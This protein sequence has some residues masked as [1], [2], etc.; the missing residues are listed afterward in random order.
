MRSWL[1]LA[2]FALQLTASPEC[3]RPS[4]ISGLLVEAGP[5]PL[6]PYR[7]CPLAVTNHRISGAFLDREAFLW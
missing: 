1:L 5:P 3:T 2:G 6:R 7:R 4:A